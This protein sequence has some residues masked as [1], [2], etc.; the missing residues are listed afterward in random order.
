MDPV[1]LF[2]FW[3]ILVRHNSV[4]MDKDMHDSSPNSHA[5]DSINGVHIQT[6]FQFHPWSF[7]RPNP[8]YKCCWNEFN[9]KQ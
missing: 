6:N 5:T 2:Y 9:F 8:L 3:P 1:L 7:K 4:G